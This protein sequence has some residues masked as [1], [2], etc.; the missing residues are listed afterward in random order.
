M[1]I[2]QCNFPSTMQMYVSVHN[3]YNKL[4]IIQ[5][6]SLLTNVLDVLCLSQNVC[7]CMD[8]IWY[9]ISSARYGRKESF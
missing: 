3:H 8:D 6:L 2:M 4:F 7:V 9:E 1:N 5:A